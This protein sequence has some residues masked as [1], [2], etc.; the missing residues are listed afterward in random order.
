[1]NHFTSV[2]PSFF[3]QRLSSKVIASAASVASVV[4]VEVVA[5]GCD[6]P[7]ICSRSLLR[8]P[9]CTDDFKAVLDATSSCFENLD[10]N[11]K[12]RC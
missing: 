9:R 4:A 3:G 10:T 6:R 5:T 12:R 1:M 11:R 2:K 8:I 7:G